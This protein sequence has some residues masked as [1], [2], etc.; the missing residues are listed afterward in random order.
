MTASMARKGIA[1]L[2]A[3]RLAEKV[4][5][6]VA[7]VLYARF[8][9]PAE[10]A[11]V[12]L[13]FLFGNLGPVLFGLGIMPTLVLELPKLA[14]TQP[15]RAASLARHALGLGVLIALGAAAIAYFLAERYMDA[16]LGVR[17]E[18]I[19]W[20]ALGVGFQGLFTL[21]TQLLVGT[22]RFVPLAV[23]NT[24]ISIL[25]LVLLVPL[26]QTA[27]TA[28]IAA[29]LAVAGG[30]GCLLALW[31]LKGLLLGGRH[32]ARYSYA[33]MLKL[34]W[35]Y[36][37]EGYLMYFRSQGDQLI[38]T[39]LL[40]VESLAQYYI[41]RR[42]YD[43]LRALSD[44]VDSALIPMLSKL[45]L[46]SS[47]RF[48]VKWHVLFRSGLSLGMLAAIACIAVAPF[49]ITVLG[50]EKYQ[51]ALLPTIILI[52]V[53]LVDLLKI[54]IGRSVFVLSSPIR[55]LQLT[56][57]ESVL[58][59]P[60]LLLGTHLMGV[61]GAALAG[62]LA[63]IAAVAYAYHML[64]NAVPVNVTPSDLGEVLLPA[65]FSFGAMAL[66]MVW[67]VS[68]LSEDVVGLGLATGMGVAVSVFVFV[69]LASAQ[70]L[71]AMTESLGFD[72][73]PV[74]R[75]ILSRVRLKRR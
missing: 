29:G 55:R 27:G 2:F 44:S 65:T 38:V 70:L 66:L 7:L 10:L 3:G 56:V 37:L 11:L 68:E 51:A 34:S 28:G 14:S 20:L 72:K 60:F 31:Q 25:R 67:A 13:L 48:A 40:G 58:L 73:L 8:F 6:F 22:S 71:G 69:N 47:E 52:L 21:L 46:E 9:T 62:L 53:F 18:T 35:P 26:H 33:Q 42:L 24:V 63:G 30:V 4:I 49:Y 32:G 23:T 5:G 74:V 36:Y 45:S 12:P 17:G 64:K 61:T 59:L 16:K 39:G 19:M 50:S 54:V 1:V 41:A 15:A 43:V 75:S 57:F